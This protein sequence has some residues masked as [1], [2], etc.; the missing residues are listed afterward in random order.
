[1]LK[2]SMHVMLWVKFYEVDIH[3]GSNKFATDV[4]DQN[5]MTTLVI[6]GKSNNH[7]IFLLW[8]KVGIITLQLA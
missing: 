1:M 4:E 8:H 7:T 2:L 6:T 3:P 5:F